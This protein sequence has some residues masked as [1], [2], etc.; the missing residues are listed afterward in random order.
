[1][2]NGRRAVRG[3]SDTEFHEAVLQMG[4]RVS[5]HSLHPPNWE[6]TLENTN[7]TFALRV[8]CVRARN[9]A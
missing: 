1:M 3:A 9:S 6:R 2:R 7:V 4:G 8:C 5:T